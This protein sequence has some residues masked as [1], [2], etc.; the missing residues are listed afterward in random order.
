MYLSGLDEWLMRVDNYITVWSFR[1]IMN[2]RVP[3]MGL[4]QLQTESVILV[5]CS[6]F[7]SRDRTYACII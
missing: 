2:G 7:T 4:F 6:Q 5:V 3:G 1:V